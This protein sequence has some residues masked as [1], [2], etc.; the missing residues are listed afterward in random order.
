MIKQG[1]PTL[2]EIFFKKTNIIVDFTLLKQYD[3]EIQRK[4]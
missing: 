4:F 1:F 3:T 2:G